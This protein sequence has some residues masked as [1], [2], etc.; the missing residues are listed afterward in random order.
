MAQRSASTMFDLPQP[1][2]PTIPVRP[3]SSSSSTGSENDL[4]PLTRSLVISNGG[5]AICCERAAPY[6]GGLRRKSP[7]GPLL[8][9]SGSI[10]AA[11]SSTLSARRRTVLPS[12]MKLG[13]ERMS[14][15]CSPSSRACRIAFSSILVGQA[16][17]DLGLRPA[18]RAGPA[19]SAPGPGRRRRAQLCCCV[20]NTSTNLGARSGPAQCA[21]TEAFSAVSSSGK[22]RST[23][24][25]LPV[26]M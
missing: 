2:G 7:T 6:Q 3:A 5:N 17:L 24:R 8:R 21:M 10:I 18:R 15:F 11:N 13:V 12:M 14:Y 1:L 26:S 23:S 4:K 25:T 20:K 19:G 9:S 16:G 22:S